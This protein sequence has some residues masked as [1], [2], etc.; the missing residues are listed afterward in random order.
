M[1]I[2]SVPYRTI[3]LELFLKNHENALNFVA[4]WWGDIGA[5]S[6]S[7]TNSLIVWS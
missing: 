6:G 1:N 4:A 7:D 5:N 2:Q 3:F